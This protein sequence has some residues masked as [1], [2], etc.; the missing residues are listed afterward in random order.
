MDHLGLDL[1][2]TTI[3]AAVLDADGRLLCT[4]TVPGGAAVAGQPWERKQ[5]ARGIEHA[6]LSL[7]DGLLQE[8]P[9]I[10]CVGLTGQM[11]GI[12][13]VDA[14]GQLL[15]PLYTWQ[16]ETGA[17]PGPDGKSTA[18]RLTARTGYPLAS[19]Y[20][21]VTLACHQ[22]AGTIPD[23]AAAVCTIADYLAMRLSGRST[24]RLT[25]SM[26]ASLGLFDG[27]DFDRK[28]VRRAGLPERLLP[29]VSEEAELGGGR[30]RVFAALGDNQASFLGAGQ[31]RLDAPL[32][33]IGTGSQFSFF[34]K[35]H[36]TVPGLETRPFP[37][38]WLLTGAPLCGGRSFALLERFFRQ[39]AELV[40]GTPCP[41][42]YP[43]MLRALE[44][45]M[46]D[47]VPQFRTTFAG[48]RQ[49]PAERAV[50]S[51]LMR[52][53]LPPFPC[54]TLC[55]A[56]WRTSFPPVTALRSKPDVRPPG[57]CLA[58]ATVCGTIPPCSVPSR[59]ALVCRSRWLPSRRRPPA[60]RRCLHVCSMRQH[61]DCSGAVI[62]SPV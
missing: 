47:D 8:F 24:P 20:G 19:G 6:A 37:G 9:D 36:R 39:T 31:G 5:D 38:G 22:A 54:C 42:A 28:A 40:T 2:T 4:R 43:A 48:T 11:H 16:D 46:P 58:P 21:L 15:S 41:S 3:S 29:E 10:G 33:N 25:P 34:T 62:Y 50:L 59:G 30:L 55:C 14:A 13:Y 57:G 53:I 27:T 12:V 52:R 44:A 51:G 23:G 32:V 17:Q 1:G 49:D 45:P 60:A 26:A 56:A 7:L 35:E 61:F 18:A